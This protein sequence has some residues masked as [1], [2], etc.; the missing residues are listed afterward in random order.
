MKKVIFVLAFSGLS[1]CL[2]AISPV[3]KKPV[4]TEIKN[5]EKPTVTDVCVTRSSTITGPEGSGFSIVVSCTQCASTAMAAGVL[6]S[7]CA[8]N[9]VQQLGHCL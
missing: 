6:A 8:S 2:F 3:E 1:T 5:V 7:V 9:V 4:G